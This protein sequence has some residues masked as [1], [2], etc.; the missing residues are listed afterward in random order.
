MSKTISA[1]CFSKDGL[2][3]PSSLTKIYEED[4]DTVV[5][6]SDGS[7]GSVEKIKEFSTNPVFSLEKI[8]SVGIAKTP[9]FEMRVIHEDNSLS[10]PHYVI[11]DETKIKW[12][13]SQI[14]APHVEI[15][16]SDIT[17][18]SKTQAKVDKKMTES[19]C[20]LG[21]KLWSLLLII[22]ERLCFPAVVID[23]MTK[24]TYNLTPQTIDV[25]LLR[26]ET[27]LMSLDYNSN[28][29]LLSVDVADEIFQVKL[30]ILNEIYGS[31]IL[32]FFNKLYGRRLRISVSIVGSDT[33]KSEAVDM[34]Y[35]ELGRIIEQMKIYAKEKKIS[36]DDIILPDD[37]IAFSKK[38][39]LDEES[40]FWIKGNETLE[41]VV[42]ANISDI[43][44][45]DTTDDSDGK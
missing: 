39:K 40:C 34:S 29:D 43:L 35:G 2:L 11:D 14:A 22:E 38:V 5:F 20:Y 10:K 25:E 41:E 17:S 44:F 6:F 45:R 31:L 8:K 12:L 24:W 23:K 28:T 1:L 3:N 32:P 33:K 4:I 42:N 16:L 26:K 9:R 7:E 21:Y 37:L 15:F 13:C 18:Q 30:S 27:G 19:I 36:P